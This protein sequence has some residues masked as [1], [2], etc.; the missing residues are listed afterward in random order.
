[1]CVTV[2]RG[3]VWLKA[4]EEGCEIVGKGTVLVLGWYKGVVDG[5]WT[6]GVGRN[7]L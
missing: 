5:S 2:M 7:A 4:G 1:M 3:W 6:F